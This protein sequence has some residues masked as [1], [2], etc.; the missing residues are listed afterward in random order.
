M[1]RCGRCGNGL[2]TSLPCFVCWDG[3]AD[4]EF[5]DLLIGVAAG[6]D[7]AAAQH[8]LGLL[9]AIDDEGAV[10]ALRSACTHGDPAIRSAVLTSLGWCGEAG[11][12]AIAAAFLGDPE[13]KVRAAARRALANFGGAAAVEALY[14]SLEAA[15]EE[16]REDVQAALAWLGDSREL[17]AIRAQA[18]ARLHES[19]WSIRPRY[20]HSEGA[21]YALIRLGTE[22]DRRA[23]I[24]E[25]LEMMDN[26]EILDPARPNHSPDVNLAQAAEV[27]LRIQLL[28][29]GFGEEADRLRDV[30]H[31]HR[32]NKL[33]AEHRPPTMTRTACE[34]LLPSSVP[35][36]TMRSLATEAP[37]AGERPAAKFGGQPDWID[38]PCWPLT[39]EDGPM[40]FWGQLPV[41]DEPGR[42]AYIF[43]DLSGDT[44]SF[45]FLGDG[46]AVIVQ[47]GPPPQVPTR[48]AATGP[49]LFECIPQPTRY[50]AASINR[51]YERFIELEAGFDPPEWTWPEL[52][53]GEYA[54]RPE[55]GW[56]K[57]GG[58]PQF[59]QGDGGPPGAGWRFAF[60]FSAA[61]AGHEIAD[62]AECYGFINTDG[63]GALG[64][65]CH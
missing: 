4:A 52:P 62:G 27:R 9:A 49:G 12:V 47:P 60:Q 40:V 11:D 56:N 63:R 58:T 6:E 36:Q 16:E 3:K 8:A 17:P 21:I 7:R 50:G 53:E 46:N 64:W 23:L 45:E 32:A 2:L 33:P 14:G 35:R 34:P 19:Q 59:L 24:D 13:A 30:F 44:D 39:P 25:V 18:I 5:V 57:L 10:T 37:P 38:T 1:E 54:A 15:S 41:M 20:L 31:E 61:W 48:E 55:D 28:N 51:V 22:T 65:D 43:M 29:A 42:M 26:A